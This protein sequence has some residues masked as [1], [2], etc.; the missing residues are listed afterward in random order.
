MSEPSQLLYLEPDDEITSVVRRLRQTDGDRVVLVA[1]GRSKVTTSAVALRLLAGVARDDGRDI[2]LVADA[3]GRALAMEAGIAAFATVGDAGE[4]GT[5]QVAEAEPV[6]RAPI[7]VVRGDGAG[8]ARA[9]VV[10]PAPAEEAPPPAPR[11]PRRMPAH[12]GPGD[13]TQAAPLPAAAVAVDKRRRAEMQR[14]LAGTSAG[15]G[16]GRRLPRVLA[17][18]AVTMVLLAGALLA[19]VAPAATIVIRPTPFAI[20]PVSYDL[21]LTP[22]GTDEGQL[23]SQQQGTASGV[24]SDPVAATGT[25]EIYNYS[26]VQ[27]EVPAGT[28]LSA[29]GAVFFTTTDRIVCEPGNVLGFDIRPS[30]TSVGVVAEE[31]GPAGNVEAEAINRVENARVDGYLRAF[32]GLTGRRVSNPEP[33]AGGSDNEEPEVTQEDVNGVVAAIQADLASQLAE[34]LPEAQGR[35]YGPV[36]AG[37]PSVDVPPDLVG[38]RGDGSF[39]L[40]GAMDYARAYVEEATVVAAARDRLVGDGGAIPDQ[41]EIVPESVRVEVAEATTSGDGLQVRVTV[42]AQAVPRVDAD[43]VRQRVADMTGPAARD[44]L[45]PLGNVSVELWPGWVDRVPRLSF[46]VDVRVEGVQ[47]APSSAPSESG[48]P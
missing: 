45:S 47:S 12:T 2:A 35:V 41:T 22:D 43:A 9:A 29:D 15:W 26:Y 23:T 1:S 46:R 5:A 33:T 4:E 32:P 34:R 38:R 44:A 19:A 18:V 21:A 17:A 3:S 13:E 27:V 36:D 40:D 39:T 48:S 8:T 20:D 30:T 42:R 14:R 7:R 6:R 16:F 11:A 24:H 37:Q 25:V 28:R 10:T 31:P